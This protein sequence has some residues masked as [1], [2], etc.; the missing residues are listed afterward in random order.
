MTAWRLVRCNPLS[1]GGVDYA[2]PKKT[3]AALFNETSTT[4]VGI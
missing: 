1:H 3:K 2:D 4:K